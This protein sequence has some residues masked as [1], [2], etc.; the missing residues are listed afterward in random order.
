[1]MSESMGLRISVRMNANYDVS[2]NSIRILLVGNQ[3]LVRAGLRLLIENHPAF[4][5]VG[6]ADGY[7][8]AVVVSKTKPIDIVLVDF[9]MNVENELDALSQLLAALDSARVILLSGSF[10]AH[11]YRS[12]ISI[13]IKGIV[14]KVHT[15]E[16]LIKAIHKVHEGEM[17]LDRST[18]ADAISNLS[19]E[20]K[21]IRSNPET[22]KI[23]SLS[24][25]EREVVALVCDGLKNKQI[26]ERL[27]ISEATVRH[28]LTSIFNKLEVSDRLDLILYSFRSGLADAPH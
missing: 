11:K 9:D 15:Q 7:P 1:M 24:Q 25:R 19:H 21:S 14:L 3:R 18:M 27:F 5:V 10:D 8:E 12:A 2:R 13:G 28:H 6:E 23:N 20:I 16:T 4:S 22:A 26:A 17:W